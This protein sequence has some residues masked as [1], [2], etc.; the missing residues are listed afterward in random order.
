MTVRDG[1]VVHNIVIFD[2]TSFAQQIGM[3]PAT[4]S[5]GDRA[6]TA[7]F[8]AWTRLRRARR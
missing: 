8:N 5:R 7:A 4:G 2:R 6:L 1:V 3:L